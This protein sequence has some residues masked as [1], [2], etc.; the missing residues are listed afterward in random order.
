MQTTTNL[1]AATPRQGANLLALGFGL[2]AVLAV[3]LSAAGAFAA[4]DTNLFALTVVAATAGLTALYFLVPPIRALATRLGPYGLAG[5]HVWRIPAALTFFYYG[6]QGWLPDIFVAL[7][8]CGDLLA[9]TLAA[10]VLVLPR[11]R[12]RIAA[13]HVF[14]FADFLVAVGTGILLTIRAPDSMAEIVWLPVALI[15]L[16]GVPLSGATHIAALHQ[17]WQGGA[18]RR[19]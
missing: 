13:F 5:F 1:K 16:V 19:F 12:R 17:L 7:A 8:G 11:S 3:A 14:G 9:G 15:P 10:A 2:Y 6:W 18:D 4:V